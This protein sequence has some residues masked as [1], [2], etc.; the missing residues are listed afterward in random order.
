MGI[1]SFDLCHCETVF[2]R[3]SNPRADYWRL[4]HK[5]LIAMTKMSVPVVLQAGEE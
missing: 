3:R 4:L 5:T 2:F 1:P